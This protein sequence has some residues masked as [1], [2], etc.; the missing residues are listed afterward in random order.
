MQAIGQ[1]PQPAPD[2]APIY[3]KHH[4]PDQTTLYRLVQEHAATFFEQAEA[5]AGA[6]LPDL[7]SGHLADPR[8]TLAEALDVFLDITEPEKP[9]VPTSLRLPSSAIESEMV[10]AQEHDP[11]KSGDAGGSAVGVRQA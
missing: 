7:Q 6:D 8:V 5:E 4:R 2:G 1:Q 3:Y 11:S 10:Q 9:E